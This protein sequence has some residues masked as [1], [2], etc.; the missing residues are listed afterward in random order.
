MT[1]ERSE[2]L[3]RTALEVKDKMFKRIAE[4][5]DIHECFETAS[6]IG[7]TLD[8]SQGLWV[9]L[10]YAYKAQE[11]LEAMKRRLMEFSPIGNG[12]SVAYPLALTLLNTQIEEFYHLQQERMSKDASLD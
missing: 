3:Q 4:S 2:T 6:V 8:N 12:S 10:G 5:K 11:I 9:E 1:P 7:I